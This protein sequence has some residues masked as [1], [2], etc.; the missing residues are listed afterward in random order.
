[1]SVDVVI[2]GDTDVLHLDALA[3]PA[4]GLNAHAGRR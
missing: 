4:A 3:A 1:V 2:H